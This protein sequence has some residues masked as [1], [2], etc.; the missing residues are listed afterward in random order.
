MP[1]PVVPQT[2]HVS[3]EL[4]KLGP[5]GV[6]LSKRLDETAHAG[7]GRLVNLKPHG[8]LES[9]ESF[10]DRQCSEL[11]VNDRSLQKVSAHVKEG[12]NIARC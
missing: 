9:L 2:Q 3:K 11:I 4:V 10:L 12:D 6:A 8:E 5:Q 7:R 1:D